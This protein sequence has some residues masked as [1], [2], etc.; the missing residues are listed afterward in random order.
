MTEATGW[1]IVISV[2]GVAALCAFDAIAHS[3][4]EWS[5]ADRSKPYWVGTL[6]VTGFFVIVAPIG[7]FGYLLGV[8]PRFPRA[9]EIP[10]TEFLKRPRN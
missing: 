2:W 9:S 10:G 3:Q 4:L 6:I 5:V 1:V 8:R 7:V